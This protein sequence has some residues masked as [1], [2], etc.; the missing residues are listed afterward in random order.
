[1]VDLP[2]FMSVLGETLVDNGYSILP[3]IPGTKIPGRYSAG[4]WVPMDKWQRF[5]D[6]PATQFELET[7]RRWTGAAVGIACGSVI[8]IDIDVMDAEVS[9]GLE[10]LAREMLGDTSAMRIGQ[11][12]K[13]ALY[14]RSDVPFVGRKRHPIEVYGRGQQMVIYAVHPVTNRP[15]EWI[16]GSGL[17]EIDISKLPEITEEQAMQWLD[18]AYK[19]IPEHLKPATLSKNT[20]KSE[21]AGPSDPKGTYEAIKSALQ[22]IPNDDLDSTSWITMANA[23]K[24]ALGD[25]GMDLWIDWSKSSAKSG[26]SGKSD[27]AER[28]YRTARP[29]DIGAGSIYYMAEQRGWRPDAGLT[30]NGSKAEQAEEIHVAA[31]LIA[32][33]QRQVMLR[34]DAPGFAPTPPSVITEGLTGLLGAFV[35]HVTATA[36][37]PQPFLA[38]GA[39]LA[40][41]GTAAGRRYRTDTN[42]RTN[43]M[44]MALADS[45]GGKERPR[46]FLAD[47]FIEAGMPEY[48]GGSRIASSAGVLTAL[49]DHPVVLFPLDE[50][51]HMLG[52]NASRNVASHKA[53]IMPLFTE[54]F[55]K[56]GSQYL[57]TSLGDSK[58]NPKVVLH[59]PH[60]VLF[61]V[62]VPSTLWRA[63]NSGAVS[64][65]SLARFLVFHTPDDYPDLQY[66]VMR[67]APTALLDGLRYLAGTAT[68]DGNL[69]GMRAVKQS[70]TVTMDAHVVPCD[71]EAAAMITEISGEELAL[72]RKHRGTAQTAIYARM[73]E[74]IIRVAMIHAL[75]DNPETPVIRR[76]DI[77][78]ARALV[79]H[80]IRHLISQV[81]EH[82]SDNETEAGHKRV[83]AIIRKAGG[84]THNELSKATQTI[85]RRD[86]D[87]ILAT[88]IDNGSIVVTLSPQ[89]GGGRPAR[90]YQVAGSVLPDDD[91]TIH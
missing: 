15:Y 41:I 48:L 83:M 75:S 11:A 72:K 77:K 29:R 43:V 38:L 40:A 1:M 59:Q 50:L 10:R 22:F 14:Y 70:S 7:W 39:A 65:G 54:L 64:D 68:G 88:L 34:G 53:E 35:D 20:L 62:T 46:E 24:A 80:C 3:I 21:W 51:G 91:V 9:I 67:K 63:F 90:F 8:G 6:A 17:T 26:A 13:R 2:S 76:V 27:T 36:R 60:V 23:I 25:D 45:G 74:H 78:W 58:L 18:E 69:A 16:D 19:R 47:V 37:S 31:G 61:G 85:K 28:R 73:T 79:T 5:C 57:G 49:K 66:P 55:S 81:T 32:N 44:I 52:I 4:N 12:P 87:D 86:K 30:L 33:M 82:I 89:P 56:A 84:I 42:I 71:D